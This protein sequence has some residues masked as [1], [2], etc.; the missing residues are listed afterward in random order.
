M[1]NVYLHRAEI[2]NPEFPDCFIG[3]LGWANDGPPLAG[4]GA[5]QALDDLARLEQQVAI[6]RSC[7]VLNNKTRASE[8]LKVF[9]VS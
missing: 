7:T 2:G 9:I 6:M 8:N 3:D 4:E 5:P 1:K